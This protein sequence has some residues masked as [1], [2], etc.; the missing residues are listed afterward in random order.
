MRARSFE[1]SSSALSALSADVQLPRVRSSA[2]SN[3]PKIKTRATRVSSSLRLSS[4]IRLPFSV[5]NY[6][7]YRRNDLLT[8]ATRNGQCSETVL[9]NQGSAYM[10]GYFHAGYL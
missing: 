4:A 9:V 6:S 3:L 7:L 10:P 2:F 5:D 1:I 8:T